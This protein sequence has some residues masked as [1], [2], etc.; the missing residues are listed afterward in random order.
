MMFLVCHMISQDHV[1]EESC[2]FTGESCEVSHHSAMFCGHTHCGSGNIM[3]LVYHV[4]S[5]DR[6]IKES[7]NIMAINT[8]IV[9]MLL[10]CHLILT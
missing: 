4:I 3:V 2:N 10:V 7:S 8:L 5:Q 9:E 6:V 1:I